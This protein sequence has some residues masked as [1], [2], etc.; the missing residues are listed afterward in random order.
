[1]CIMGCGKKKFRNTPLLN[2]PALFLNSCPKSSGL[3]GVVFGVSLSVLMIELRKFLGEKMQSIYG[4]RS[5][6]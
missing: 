2:N 6:L 5:I 1:M 4:A 3:C